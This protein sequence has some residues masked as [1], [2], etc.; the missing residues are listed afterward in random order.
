MDE[1]RLRFC[2]LIVE[3]VGKRDA[4]VQAGY[5]PRTGASIASRLLKE[6][7][8]KAK[9]E[10]L[11]RERDEQIAEDDERKLKAHY[12]SSLDLFRD[13]YNNPKLPFSVR[14]AA[15]KEALPYEHGKVGPKGKRGSV[16]DEAEA[17]ANGGGKS[18]FAPGA[19][20]AL[21]AVS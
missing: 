15:A 1:R 7:A 18:K 10:E 13:V 16:K 14:M 17:V 3:N 4:A 2:K 21:R 20:P 11:R 8:I 9:I 19:R 12:D 5:S 6:K